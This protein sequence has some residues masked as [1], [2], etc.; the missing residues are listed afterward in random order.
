MPQNLARTAAI[1]IADSPP[2]PK[3][4]IFHAKCGKWWTGT[5]TSHCSGCCETFT[6]LT[7]FDAHRAGS[8]ARGERHC[9]PPGTVGLADAGRAY[10]CWGTPGD[11]TEWWADQ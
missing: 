11:G 8:H 5:L 1:G 9:L 6:G 7:A 4:A 10:A 2:A 3:N